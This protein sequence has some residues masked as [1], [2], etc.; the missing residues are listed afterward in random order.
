MKVV[1]T[2]GRVLDAE[3]T[4]EAIDGQATL[5]LE[6]RTGS[7]R[8]P[9]YHLALG[10]LLTRLAVLDGA[11]TN[12]IV[13]SA[14]S[15]RL[16]FEQRQ[17]K[18]RDRPFPVRPSAE[19]DI[20]DLRIAIGAA[21]EPVAQRPGAKGGNRHKRIRLYLDVDI[22]ATELATRL[23]A[24]APPAEG[25]QEALD[26]IE[27][28]ARLGGQARGQGRGL[29]GPERRAVEMRAMEVACERLREDGWSVE[30]VSARRSY[31]LHCMHRGRELRVE[32]KGTT[33][34]GA[35]ILLTRT[36]VHHATEHAAEVAL[37]V[38]SRIALNRALTP[39]LAT[40]GV[41]R[42]L[43]RWRLSAGVLEPVGYEWLLP[44]EN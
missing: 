24:E 3:F 38:V 22:A 17:L 23:A 18:L 9:D 31:D 25:V 43:D 6:S 32:V 5:V 7:V 41:L 35:S 37:Y 29:T 40:G 26:V 8:N 12:A 42:I 28:V 14:V 2:D 34:A 44:V 20:E 27:R 30:D 13:D 11:I 39:P 10:N 33:G 1:G 15:R 16:P 4:I 36:E 21:Q 19:T